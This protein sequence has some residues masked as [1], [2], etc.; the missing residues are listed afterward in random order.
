MHA[1]V[2]NT[3]T[4]LLAQSEYYFSQS[5]GEFIPVEQMPL[6]YAKNAWG[7]LH[8][9]YGSEFIGSPLCIALLKRIMPTTHELERTLRAM[10]EASHYAEPSNPHGV[11]NARNKFYRA[12]ARMGRRV[13]THKDGVWVRGTCAP[14]AVNIRVRR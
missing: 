2:Q 4:A 9:E 11:R 7:K 1:P 14:D 3:N 10:G 13:E 12:A 5:A 8:E 6:P